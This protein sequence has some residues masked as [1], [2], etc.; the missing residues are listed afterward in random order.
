MAAM[1]KVTGL[2]KASVTA[3][4][5]LL[6]EA[7]YRPRHGRGWAAAKVTPRDA[8]RLLIAGMASAQLK[9]AVQSVDRYGAARLFASGG[10][11]EAYA[12]LGI[13]ELTTLADAHN[14]LDAVE[15]L[16][17]SAASGTLACRM[18]THGETIGDRLIPAT[19]LIELTLLTPA[20]L[21]EI[22]IAGTGGN[23]ARTA[24]YA[25]PDPW[26]DAGDHEPSDDAIT[27]WAAARKAASPTGDLQ[28]FRRITATTV[29]TLARLFTPTAETNA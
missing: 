5:R 3:L 2:P 25:L 7:G 14:V 19:P 13:A 17:V 12:G 24:R 29:L 28:Q 21:A 16:L 27:A 23:V 6:A 26:R 8:A 20:T 11:A 15:A 4:D 10:A 22:R 1:A 9:D 18:I